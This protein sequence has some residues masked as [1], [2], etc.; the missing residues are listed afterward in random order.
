MKRFT[1]T[2][3]LRAILATVILSITIGFVP[4]VPSIPSI[5]S[6]PAAGASEF[7]DVALFHAG[8]TRYSTDT[9]AVAVDADGYV[10][11]GTNWAGAGDLG[12][13]DA[14]HVMKGY[15]ADA[16]KEAWAVHKVSPTGEEE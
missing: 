6:V 3:T 16:A 5:S 9:S 4:F 1:W 8:H 15:P 12:V 10:Y 2:S 11:T 7:E 14:S 13:G